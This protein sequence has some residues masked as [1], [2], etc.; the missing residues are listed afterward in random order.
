MTARTST[1]GSTAAQNG[2]GS[3]ATCRLVHATLQGCRTTAVGSEA[4]K[5]LDH[6]HD[7]TILGSYRVQDPQCPFSVVQ[8]GTT[9]AKSL[10]NEV[11]AFEQT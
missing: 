9:H 5:R 6:T 10:T 3:Q 2:L 11:S 1:N 4:L 8:P 7:W